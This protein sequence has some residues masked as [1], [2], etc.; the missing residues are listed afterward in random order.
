MVP[1]L[2]ED[3]LIGTLPGLYNKKDSVII[4]LKALFVKAKIVD[5]IADVEVTQRFVNEQTH[6]IEAV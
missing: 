5:F 2:G 4:P 3:D 6:P 1:R